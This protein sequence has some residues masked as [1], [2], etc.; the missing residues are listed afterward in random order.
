MKQNKT[1]LRHFFA[2]GSIIVESSFLRKSFDVPIFW[3]ALVL[4]YINDKVKPE[5]PKVDYF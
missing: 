4:S 2:T 5:P 3:Q 1:N